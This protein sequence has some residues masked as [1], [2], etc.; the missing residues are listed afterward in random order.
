L[1]QAVN[2]PVRRQRETTSA[3]FPIGQKPDILLRDGESIP[4]EQVIVSMDTPLEND[5]AA[6]LKFAEE[7]VTILIYP[8][9]E[10]NAPIVVDCW[11]NGKGAEVF[12]NGQWHAFNCLPVNIAVT[13]KRKYVEVLARSKIDTINTM[14]DDATV[15]NPANRINRVT[16]SSAVFT[17]IG[18]T[19]PKGVEWLKRLMTQ[20]G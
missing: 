14:V 10:K 20:Q 19:N 17:V 13:T 6:Q 16:S 15:E 3:D 5:Y 4:R 11:V 12:V 7:P 8:S 2:T 18:D 1:N 9:R